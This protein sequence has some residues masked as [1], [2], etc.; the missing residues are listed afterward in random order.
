VLV[1]WAALGTSLPLYGPRW[2]RHGRGDDREP[3]RL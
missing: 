2:P 1:I 3:V